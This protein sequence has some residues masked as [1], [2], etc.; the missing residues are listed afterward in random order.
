MLVIVIRDDEQNVEQ[1]A[2]CCFN[3]LLLVARY[4]EL[5]IVFLLVVNLRLFFSEIIESPDSSISY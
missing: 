5:I 2:R 3:L 1:K 4:T